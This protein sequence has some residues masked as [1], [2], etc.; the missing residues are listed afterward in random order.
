MQYRSRWM[1][2]LILSVFFLMIRRPPRSTR[3]DTLFPYTTL[4]RSLLAPGDAQVEAELPA[5]LRQDPVA[6]VDARRGFV[7]RERHVRRPPQRLL[8]HR[9]H[10]DAR[11]RRALR[12]LPRQ[13]DMPPPT[14][15]TACRDRARPTV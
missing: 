2:W 4:F 14:G 9:R 11:P 13:P 1:S 10:D 8:R 3:T 5:P 12:I 7:E 6:H 15:R